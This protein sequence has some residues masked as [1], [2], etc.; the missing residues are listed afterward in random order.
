MCVS[1]RFKIKMVFY[2]DRQNSMFGSRERNGLKNQ[3][4]ITEKK[5]VFNLLYGLI[6][7]EREVISLIQY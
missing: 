2:T 6:R 3:S 5:N 4:F 7:G 1:P